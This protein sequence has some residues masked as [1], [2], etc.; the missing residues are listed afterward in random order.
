MGSNALPANSPTPDALQKD[1]STHDTDVRSLNACPGSASGLGTID[2]FAPFQ[3]STR[4]FSYVDNQP[5]TAVHAVAAVHEMAARPEGYVSTFGEG[6]MDHVAPFHDSMRVSVT[7]PPRSKFPALPTA[8][9]EVAPVHETPAKP[10]SGP[11]GGFG[12]GEEDQAEP[13]H[14]SIND[15]CGE[16]PCDPTAKQ[17]EASVHEMPLRTLV[18][19]DH[20]P[21]TSTFDQSAPSHSSASGTAGS[22]PLDP[23][24]MHREVVAQLTPSKEAFIDPVGLGDG[25]IDQLVPFQISAKVRVEAG[26]EEVEKEPTAMQNVA[27]RHDTPKR[28]LP[29]A[30]EGFGLGIVDQIGGVRP[31]AATETVMVPVRPTARSIPA[32]RITTTRVNLVRMVITLPFE[33]DVQQGQRA[34]MR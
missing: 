21:G 30:F 19:V 4:V 26:D 25:K 28:L 24:A 3:F 31:D 29:A 27:S 8:M 20:G 23:T 18:P 15:D 16:D 11:S 32:L 14:R 5:P 12:L 6:T 13:F 9:Q 7:P 33:P 17:D 2:H 10:T 22:K 1:G 34:P